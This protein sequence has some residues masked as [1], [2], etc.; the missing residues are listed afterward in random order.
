[1]EQILDRK[2]GR[3]PDGR[4]FT[5]TYVDG[6]LS[7]VHKGC[8]QVEIYLSFT[9]VQSSVHMLAPKKAHA[10][11]VLTSVHFIGQIQLKVVPMT[12]PMRTRI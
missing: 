4:S 8:L 7:M 10:V 12:Y 2:E 11:S 9:V 5:C 1:M 3:L 6:T